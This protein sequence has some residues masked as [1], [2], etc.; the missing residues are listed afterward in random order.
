MSNIDPEIVFQRQIN[1]I[2]TQGKVAVVGMPGAAIFTTLLF[3]GTIPVYQLLIWLSIIIALTLIR[4]VLIL[5]YQHH[6]QIQHHRFWH[7]AYVLLELCSGATWASLVYW[8]F[9]PA[10]NDQVLIL[11]ILG[12]MAT[13]AATMLTPVKSIYGAYM[14]GSGVP[15]TI[16]LYFQQTDHAIYLSGMSALYALVLWIS[17]NM[18]HKRNTDG[19]SLALENIELVNSMRRSNEK[20]EHQ[21]A[22][23]LRAEE[24][25]HAVEA[26]FRTLANATNEGVLLYENDRIVDCNQRIVEM[27]GYSAEELFK[28]DIDALFEGNNK[29]TIRK[30][31]RQDDYFNYE[32][33]CVRK[34]CSSFPAEINK[35]RLRISNDSVIDVITVHDITEMER[36]AAIKEQFISTVSHELR[37]PLTS[38]HA[39][40]GLILGGVGGELDT[41]VQNLLLIA[42]QNSERLATLIN[43]LLDIQ[44]L[45]SG[46]LSFQSESL[47]IMELVIQ[48]IELNNA[49]VEKF[50]SRFR[51]VK[52]AFHIK[53]LADRN[54]LIQVMTNL[55]SNA[56]KFSPGG[57]EI[58]IAVEQYGKM[59]RVSVR[60]QGPG[61]PEDFRDQIFQR[62]SQ[63]DATTTRN[64]SGSGLG[65]Y[66]SRQIIES[67]NGEIGFQSESGK[68]S[69]FYFSL[70]I[71]TDEQ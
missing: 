24:H 63:A 11:L 17:A 46:K 13:G 62:F 71:I 10:M 30:L 23:T 34:D 32:M 18:M 50:Q 26:R 49:Y 38:I 14:F 54:R 41:R 53:V 66:I 7:R 43:D 64:H 6:P 35:R 36:M 4:L 5:R 21:V 60:D 19:I 58:E 12:S 2:Y 28:L 61:I 16:A 33:R 45:D 55:L 37:T 51:V 25:S 39:S 9:P 22:Q 8:L 65:L 47:D 67:M 15:T 48:A 69:S 52:E 29:Y 27:L 20:L 68:G 70:P 31:I 1:E 57:S 3:W 56:S 44:K 59:V 40:L 42:K